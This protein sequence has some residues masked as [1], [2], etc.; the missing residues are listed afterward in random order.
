MKQLTKVFITKIFT[1]QYTKIFT[2]LAS[3]SY[4]HAALWRVYELRE[5]DMYIICLFT[6]NFLFW[7]P[8]HNTQTNMPSAIILHFV[9]NNMVL[10]YNSWL[11]LLWITMRI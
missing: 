11:L 4:R 10:I 1:N 7:R 2:S 3:N 9:E 8:L 5:R 6:T